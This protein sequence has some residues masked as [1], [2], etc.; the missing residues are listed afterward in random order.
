MDSPSFNWHIKPG[1]NKLELL[2]HLIELSNEFNKPGHFNHYLLKANNDY[3]LELVH[4]FEDNHINPDTGEGAGE[5]LSKHGFLPI[6]YFVTIKQRMNR[7]DA[8]VP[9]EQR[10]VI[11]F[12]DEVGAPL[13]INDW[14]ELTNELSRLSMSTEDVRSLAET[15]EFVDKIYRLDEID[16]VSPGSY[17]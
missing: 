13:N 5:I 2:E 6:L 16:D 9:K 3:Q 1:Q 7:L 17:F 10:A 4:G 14:S 15:V 8:S 11:S 12:C